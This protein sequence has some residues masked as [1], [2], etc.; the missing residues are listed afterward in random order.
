LS[1]QGFYADANFV[2]VVVV[3]VVGVVGVVVV[4]VVNVTLFPRAHLLSARTIFGLT[5]PVARVL[6]STMDFF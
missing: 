1:Q 5:P 2:V 6:I 4:G 3:L